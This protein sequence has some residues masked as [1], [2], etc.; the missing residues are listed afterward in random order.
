MTV[1][2]D[3]ELPAEVREVAEALVSAIGVDLRAL[4]WHGSWARGEASAASDHDMIV[5]LR[6]LDEDVARRLRNV[7]RGSVNWSSFVQTEAELRQFPGDGRLRFHYGLV[8]LY[9]DSIPRPLRGSTLSTT[10]GCSRVT[11][12]SSL[13]TD[14][15]T[16]N[17]CTLRRTSNWPPSRKRET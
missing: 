9:G 12:A 7:F 8:P 2:T 5:V 17:P 6:R 15:S 10:F 11:S 16:S 1:R 13:A 14:C 4:L 3:I